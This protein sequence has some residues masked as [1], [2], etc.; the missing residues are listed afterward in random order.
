MMR[1]LEDNPLDTVT[2]HQAESSHVIHP[3]YNDI[4]QDTK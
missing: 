1:G 2:L 4:I 3:Q